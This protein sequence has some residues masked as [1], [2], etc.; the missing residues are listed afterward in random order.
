[1]QVK[2]ERSVVST[3]EESSFQIH[4]LE[5]WC[6]IFTFYAVSHEV[7]D[8]IIAYELKLRFFFMKFDK[9]KTLFQDCDPHVFPFYQIKYPL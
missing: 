9:F 4:F 1:M 3:N 2:G 6:L 5:K 8:E 7:D